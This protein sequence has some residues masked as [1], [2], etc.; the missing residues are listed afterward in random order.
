M[1]DLPVSTVKCFVKGV[2]SPQKATQE[3]ILNFLNYEDWETLEKDA[4]LDAL[5]KGMITNNQ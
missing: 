1:I 5:R 4:L 2:H 3:K